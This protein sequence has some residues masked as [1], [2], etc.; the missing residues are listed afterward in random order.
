[1]NNGDITENKFTSVRIIGGKPRKIIVDQTGKIVNRDPSKEELKGLNIFPEKDGRCRRE[2]YNE[3]NA[4]N[5]CGKSFN[6][7]GWFQYPRRECDKYGEL[8]G[9][10][11]CPR[12]WQ[13]Y[14][15]NSTNNL[16]RSVANCR[17]DNQDPNHN[18]T[19]GGKDIEL[20]CRLYGYTDLNKKYDKYDT[21]IDC[22]DEK[23][24]LLYQVEGRRYNSSYRRWKFSYLEREW[25]KKYGSMIFICKNKDGKIVE[26]IYR[27]PSWEIN[28]RKAITIY[29][30]PTDWVG[31]PKITWYEK[32]RV[33]NEE[34]L[35]RANDILQKILNIR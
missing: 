25:F 28:G 29:K 9:K 13:I 14:D 8:T 7:L 18:S 12:C 5:R 27:F 1:M 35:K 15:P 3:T 19:K 21:S 34:E 17:T 2:R 30:N 33:K 16:I 23:T 6:E 26:R 11:D 22:L 20:V 4:C 32:Y 31:D 24:G 10:W